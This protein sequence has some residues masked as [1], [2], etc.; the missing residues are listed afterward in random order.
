M[1]TG[2]GDETRTHAQWQ[3]LLLGTSKLFKNT[4]KSGEKNCDVVKALTSL[5]GNS[6]PAL[7]PREYI[8]GVE[9]KSHALDPAVHV[10][11]E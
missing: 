5:N 8:G 4:N 2:I 6:V 9:V 11:G 3:P 10:R 7:K 1:L